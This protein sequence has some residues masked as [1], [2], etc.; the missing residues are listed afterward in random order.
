MKNKATKPKPA[1]SMEV[2]ETAP[3]E[4]GTAEETQ[5]P[6]RGRKRKLLD[7]ESE[8][9]EGGE[10]DESNGPAKKKQKKDDD[11]RQLRKSTVQ[12]TSERKMIRKIE[13]DEAD[14][15]RV[16][17]SLFGHISS[18]TINS[19]TSHRKNEDKTKKSKNSTRK[20]SCWQRRVRLKKSIRSHSLR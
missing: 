3:S 20:Q 14:Q 9:K 11:A 12:Y 15:R 7:G 4:T 10:A 17:I 18:L 16:C 5:A 8:Q 13:R 2:T 19:R 1:V 6:R